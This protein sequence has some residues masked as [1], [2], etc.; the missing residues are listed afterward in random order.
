M[1][2]RV[3][4]IDAHQHFWDPERGD[5]FWLEPGSS[6]HRVF[7]PK[8][9]KPSLD[10]HEIDGTVLVQAAPTRDETD[11]LLTLA[12]GNPA[13]LGVVGWVDFEDR[14]DS[15]ALDRFALHPKFKGVRPMI[16]DIADPKW[17]CHANLNWA[18]DRIAELKL[19]FD[20]LVYP[21]HV[22]FLL[23]RL[24]REHELKVVID[25]GA[26]PM[27]RDRQFDDWAHDM[28]RLARETKA[29]VKLSGLV[30]E[31]SEDWS[32][33][34]LRPYADHLLGTFGPER[35]IWGSDWPVCLLAS[36]YDRWVDTA[37]MLTESCTPTQ[38]AA[39]FGGNAVAFYGLD[40]P[41]S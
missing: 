14:L 24:G 28:T 18:F 34:G 3:P 39:V 29:F 21:E 27:I 6:L 35:L 37:E 41:V 30:T 9:L 23:K 13:V 32:A 4:R 5:Y 16:Q 1:I 38:K 7:A 36:S 33:E 15:A 26:K 17:V 12:E 20:A 2:T 22:P 10:R 19:C 8:D 40:V 11:Y 31:A 25:H